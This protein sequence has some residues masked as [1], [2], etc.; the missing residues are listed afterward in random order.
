MVSSLDYQFTSGDTAGRTRARVRYLRDVV[1]CAR[2]ALDAIKAAEVDDAILDVMLLQPTQLTFSRHDR[3]WPLPDTDMNENVVGPI[4]QLLHSFDALG[5]LNI[6]EIEK[7]V[8]RCEEK[9]QAALAREAR[10]T[11]DDVVTDVSTIV[12]A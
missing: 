9:V 7:L 1:R 6:D 11:S 2:K 10:W 3:G 5:G 8:A 12:K 4:G